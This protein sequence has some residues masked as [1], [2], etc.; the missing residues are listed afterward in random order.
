MEISP[1]IYEHAAKLLDETPWRVSRDEELLYQAHAAAYRTY[2]H[3]PIMPG[4]DIY[5]LEVE[6]YGAVIEEPVECAIPA[7]KH[8]PYKTLDDIFKLPPLN[9]ETDGRIPMQIRAARRLLETFPQAVVRVPISGPFSIL[10]NLLG[11]NTV[12]FAVI[13]DPDRVR[14]ALLHLVDG[15]LSF[16]RGVKNAGVDITFFESAACPP[17]LSPKLFRLIELPALKKILNGMAEIIGRPIPC[18]IGGNTAAI[19]EPM[20]ETGTSYLIC[21][22][23]TN[24]EAFLAKVQDRTDVQIRINCDLRIISAGTREEIRREADRVIALCRKRP[25][26][27]L[28][29][30]ALP[31]EASVDNV[32]YTMEYVRGVE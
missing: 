30:G 15:Q 2:K 23:E 3:A 4:I 32:L 16:A 21:P 14:E 10:C 28:G 29:T 31:Y 18:V 22:F 19:V 17:M 13:D 5:N 8:H 1:S 26:V 6:A 20:L 9:A 12:M 7:V 24:Q 11:F 27:C 25:N